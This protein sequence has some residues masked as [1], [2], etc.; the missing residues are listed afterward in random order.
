[1]NTGEDGG[2]AEEV[3]SVD[4]CKRVLADLGQRL[5]VE[6]GNEEILKRVF[7]GITAWAATPACSSDYADA[8]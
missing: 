2:L 7:S 8:A 5:R 3:T 6:R 1:L 4:H